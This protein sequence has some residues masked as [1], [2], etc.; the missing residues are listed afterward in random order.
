MFYLNGALMQV[1]YVTPEYLETAP[2]FLPNLHA[3]VPL[4]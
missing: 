1:V 3:R 2:D 4:R